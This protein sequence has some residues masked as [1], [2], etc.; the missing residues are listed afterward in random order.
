MLLSHQ[1]SLVDCESYDEFVDDTDSAT[2]GYEV[3]KLSELLLPG[4]K[5][6]RTCSYVNKKPGS[7]YAYSNLNYV[8]MGTLLERLTNTRF[9]IWMR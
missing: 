8:I 7:Y 2:N 6:Y 9:D 4:G 5:Y 3:P 1:S